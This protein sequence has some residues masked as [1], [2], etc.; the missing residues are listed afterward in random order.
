[1]A[2]PVLSVRPGLFGFPGDLGL[3]TNSKV[4]FSG[5]ANLG[6]VST[7]VGLV[8]EGPKDIVG[9]GS[10]NLK[11][12]VVVVVDVTVAAGTSSGTVVDVAEGLERGVPNENP[13]PGVD[14]KLKPPVVVVVVTT[15]L[16]LL[17]EE[18][19]DVA[20]GVPNEKP[21]PEANVNFG[22]SPPALRTPLFSFLGT[23][24]SFGVSQAK[25]YRS[26]AL[27]LM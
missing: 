25:Q 20:A 15:L 4:G 21:P 23:V 9:L 16:V 8:G 14:P 10:S 13:D 5:A 11:L 7:A 1:M 12:L 6:V 2:E 26:S 18:V 22:A 3:K 17:T 27:L 19:V 24:E